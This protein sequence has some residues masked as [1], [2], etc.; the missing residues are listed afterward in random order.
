MFYQKRAFLYASLASLNEMALFFYIKK[1]HI[2][3]SAALKK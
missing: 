1:N 2:T 3:T